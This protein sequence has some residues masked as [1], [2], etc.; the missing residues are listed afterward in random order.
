MSY[1]LQRR[2]T[3]TALWFPILSLI[4]ERLW[5]IRS[6]ARPFGGFRGCVATENALQK[7][8][9][10]MWA[11]ACQSFCLRVFWGTPSAIMTIQIG[12]HNALPAGGVTL[13]GKAVF[14]KSCMR[15]HSA[16]RHFEHLSSLIIALFHSLGSTNDALGV[17][18]LHD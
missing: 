17:L 10:P 18:L 3:A 16:Y 15:F 5:Q 13:S 2:C 4:P 1:H 8:F 7:L 12:C 6:F 9:Q 11:R 14:V